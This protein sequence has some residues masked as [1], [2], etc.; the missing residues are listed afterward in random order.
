MST[1]SSIFIDRD[2]NTKRNLINKGL[3]GLINLGNTCY[4]NSAIHCLSQTPELTQYFITD[5][6]AEDFDDEK[7]EHH[8]VNEWVRL[9]KGLWSENCVIAPH[10]F[11]K[12]INAMSI[13]M[14]I[15]SVY[16]GNEQHD[17]QEFLQFLIDLMHTA[18]SREVVIN[19][20]GVVKTPVDKMAVEAMKCWRNYFKDNFSLFVELFYGQ[21]A[22]KTKCPSCKYTSYAYDPFCFLTL[23]LPNNSI[24][25]NEISG[26]D[27]YNVIQNFCNNESLD[28]DNKWKCDKCKIETKAERTITIWS[29][30][31][32][33]IIHLKRFK[34]DGNK[35]DIFVNYPLYKLNLSRFCVGYDKFHSEY[36]LYA[37]ACHMGTSEGGH[38]IAYCKNV[39]NKWYK[40][41]DNIV[42]EVSENSV[43]TKDAYCLFYS[44][45]DN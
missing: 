5:K 34:N 36:N 11:N 39:N 8:T 20:S 17:L 27:L 44:K 35:N 22:S 28:D 21:F 45:N 37:V 19:I 31:N 12:V 40:F 7:I 25:K 4:Q 29:T 6:Y 24:I 16:G 38:Y 13:R 43:I 2:D 10:S 9:L 3:S 42:S 23:S 1:Q 32:K 15:A 14:G 30:P 18:L 41:D 33:L 26:I